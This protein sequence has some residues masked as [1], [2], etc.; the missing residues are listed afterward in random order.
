MGFCF[1]IW[2]PIYS[3]VVM[4]CLLWCYHRGIPSVP[5]RSSSTSTWDF[6]TSAH[7]RILLHGLLSLV[8]LSFLSLLHI[9]HQHTHILF[10]LSYFGVAL[11]FPFLLNKTFHKGC[12]HYYLFLPSPRSGFHLHQMS[13]NVLFKITNGLHISKSIINS[14]VLSFLSYLAYQQRLTID[15]HFLLE[16]CFSLIGSQVTTSLVLPPTSLPLLGFLNWFFPPSQT[17]K[18]QWSVIF[19]FLYSVYLLPW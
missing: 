11:P 7:S 12:C 1:Y 2:P 5:N 4:I 17:F 19:L 13:E 16:T 10:S 15:Y 14:W 18:P 8:P 9:S 6:M 3:P